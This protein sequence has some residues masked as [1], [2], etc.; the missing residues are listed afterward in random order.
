MIRIHDMKNENRWQI[1]WALAK[2]DFK[3]RYKSS[4]L[5]FIWVIMKPL[6]TFAILSLVF[7]NVFKG[8]REY[9]IGM[10][11]GIMLWNFFSEG[12]MTGMISFFAKSH[13][14]KKIFIPRWIIIISSSLNITLNF[15]INLVVL[16]VFYLLY[17]I[18]PGIL[19]IF[20]AMYYCV[21]TYIMIISFSF[22]T[23]PLFVRLRDLDQIWEV[24]L[25]AGFYTA[26]IIYPIEL[27]P[28]YVQTL[29]Y[30]N[31]M[32]FIIV[33]IKAILVHQQFIMPWH[34]LVFTF[35]VIV[36]F[37]VSFMVFRKTSRRIA[38]YL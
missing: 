16:A 23:A 22:L 8:G 35:I 29:L 31:P 17:G 25:V 13:I 10:F 38:E 11:T 9:S 34:N 14:V 6:S 7:T 36:V 1:V 15:L 20:I 19:C 12:T 27:M 28:P 21:L 18:T 5:G 4:F 37:I 32:T 33:H 30:I 26:P 24:L 2:T 3:L